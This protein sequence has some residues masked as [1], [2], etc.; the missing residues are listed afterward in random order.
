MS[1]ATGVSGSGGKGSATGAKLG[2]TSRMGPKSMPSEKE[3]KMNKHLGSGK[4]KAG[5]G[6]PLY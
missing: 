4:Q 6:A 3:C 2:G 5:D 1:K